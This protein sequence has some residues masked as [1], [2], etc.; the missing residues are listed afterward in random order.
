M[1]QVTLK[2][3]IVHTSG[4]L[5][6]EGEKAPEFSLVDQNLNEK[7]LDSYTGKRKVIN[8]FVS[9]DTGTCANSVRQFNKEVSQLENTVVLCIS[10]DLPFA[11]KRFCGAEGVENVETLS[12]YNSSFSKDYGLEF[13]DSG[14]KGLCS[15][16][17][18]ILN[19]QN[20][21]I[22]KEQVP[23]TSEEPNYKAALAVL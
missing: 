12:A 18:I 19:E 20:E 6:N 15:R 9:I 22:Y 7:T 23:E 1:S 17:I 8:T 10:K 5:P 2:G 11:F 3:T 21:V 4:H 13:I 16:A 14:L